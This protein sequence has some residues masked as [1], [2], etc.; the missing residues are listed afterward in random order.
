MFIMKAEILVVLY[1]TLNLNFQSNSPENY[2]LPL[3]LLQGKPKQFVR[4]KWSKALDFLPF[5]YETGWGW[6]KFVSIQNE[7]SLVRRDTDI[8]LHSI[9]WPGRHP[10]SKLSRK[11]SEGGL[12]LKLCLPGRAQTSTAAVTWCCQCRR[13]TQG[14]V[15]SSRCPAQIL[16][17]ST[18]PCPAVSHCHQYKDVHVQHKLLK[19]LVHFPAL[20]KKILLIV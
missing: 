20:L 4:K 1:F 18:R 13:H 6:F 16:T 15:F 11:A 14:L 12:L 7:I 2:S 8:Q 3:L 10:S 5:S 19:F 9:Q 17:R